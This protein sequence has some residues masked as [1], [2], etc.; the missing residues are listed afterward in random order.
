MKI[1][2]K[3]W[4]ETAR[5]GATITLQHR[6]RR[7]VAHVP[8]VQPKPGNTG[9]EPETATQDLGAAEQREGRKGRKGRGE[10]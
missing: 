5:N 9:P 1:N 6:T 7:L 3:D 2:S 4:V 8:A 10:E